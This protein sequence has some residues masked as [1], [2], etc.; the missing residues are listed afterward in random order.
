MLLPLDRTFKRI[1]FVGAGGCSMSGLALLMKEKGYSVT[2]SDRTSSHKTGHLISMGIPV[3]IGHSEENVNGA[4]L[5][6]YTAAIPRGNAELA[7][8]KRAGIALMER[9][10][11]LSLL[12]EGYVNRVCVS[13]THGKTTTTSMISQILVEAGFDPTIHIG[14]ELDALGGG[15]VLGG[16]SIFVTEA[17]EFNGTFLLLKPTLSIIL[18]IGEDH[19]DCYKDIDDIESAFRRFARGTPEDGWCAGFGD[20]FRVRRVLND[21]RCNT[22]SFGTGPH[23]ELRAERVKFDERGCASFIAALAGHPLAEINLRVP[24]EHNMINALAA[25]AAAEILGVSM[26]RASEILHSFK[27]ARRRF[28]LTSVTDGVNVYHDYGHNPAEIKCA[29]H[30]ANLQRHNK[31]WAIWQPHTY[32][33]TK[34]LF[35]GFLTAFDEADAVLITDICA[36]R[37]IDPG[38]INS[39]MLVDALSARG[40]NAVLTPS[41]ND[42]ENY[43]RSSWRPGDMAITLGCGDIDLLNE[44]IALHGDSN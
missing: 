10:E 29:I 42:A 13:G 33:R 19:L 32:S 6:V 5:V 37:E 16:D 25:I 14:G 40:I 30:T 43:L 2:G 17:D 8:A 18:N 34:T 12:M 11:F 28:E 1:H 31:L 41:F 44:Q 39:Q 27:N 7:E 20:D 26:S 15:V 35:D 9:K 21:L 24:G 22:R 4:D 36:A 23:N 38:D 3:M